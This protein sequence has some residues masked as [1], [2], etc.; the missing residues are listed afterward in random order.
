MQNEKVHRDLIK[1]KII[2]YAIMKYFKIIVLLLI[3]TKCSLNNNNP[4]D[5]ILNIELDH[6]YPT[7]HFTIDEIIKLETNE[8]SAIGFCWKI[9]QFKSN[10]YLLDS[11]QRDIKIFN[12]DGTYLNKIRNIGKG[13][14][15]YISIADMNINPWMD[16]LEILDPRGKLLSYDLKKTIYNPDINFPNINQVSNFHWYN[17]DKMVLHSFYQDSLL[18]LYDKSN[19]KIEWTKLKSEWVRTG[20]ASTFARSPFWKYSDSLYYLD[21]NTSTIYRVNDQGISKRYT[22]FY[23]ENNFEYVE[24]QNIASS[25]ENMD[26]YLAEKNKAFP[27][28]IC[29]ES[30]KYLGI[31]IKYKNMIYYNLIDK[32]N[33]KIFSLPFGIYA[34]NYMDFSG[35]ANGLNTDNINVLVRRPEKFRD[36]FPEIKLSPEKQRILDNVSEN[37]NPWLVRLNIN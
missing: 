19:N 8:S 33:G 35:F 14:H 21:Q 34:Q 29:F 26:H 36:I 2:K 15:E 7:K 5:N 11:Q 18:R 23:G 24:I 32:G 31:G 27:I 25:I 28:M 3:L 17:S 37:D 9:L 12:K 30:N 6:V 13:E 4:S 20:T 22:I 16:A 1:P 10:Y